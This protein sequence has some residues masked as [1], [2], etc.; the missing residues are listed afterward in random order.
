MALRVEAATDQDAERGLRARPPFP[1]AVGQQAALKRAPAAAIK[2]PGIDVRRLQS[3]K[4]ARRTDR[5]ARG[6]ER[7]VGKVQVE[8][9]AEVRDAAQLEA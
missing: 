4:S 8:L 5:D 1:P 7:A 3:G 9:G 6:S 2:W